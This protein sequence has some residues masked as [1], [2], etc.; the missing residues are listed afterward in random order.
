MFTPDA[1]I[2]FVELEAEGA[3][4][5]TE[6]KTLLLSIP[7]AAELPAAKPMLER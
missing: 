7:G 6:F 4:S 3:S 2:P 5:W 1:I